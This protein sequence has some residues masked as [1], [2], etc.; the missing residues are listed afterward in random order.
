MTHRVVRALA[1]P[2]YFFAILLILFPFGDLLVNVWPAQP[3]N[4]Q[5]RYGTVGL[6]SGMWLTPLFGVAFLIV[7]ATLL[8]HDMVLRILGAVNVV[9]AVILSAMLVLF[10]LDWLQVRP[11]IPD[12]GRTSMDVGS[13]KALL[14]HI[15]VIVL[16]GWTGMAGWLAGRPEQRTRRAQPPLIREA[17]E[18]SA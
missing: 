13:I 14:K 18:P 16:V 17:K 1:W 7:C 11:T 3:A 9:A 6:L 4:L 8:E 2:G 5:W 15:L 10:V 12:E